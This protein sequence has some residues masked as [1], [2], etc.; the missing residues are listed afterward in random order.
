M[1]DFLRRSASS[2]V[3]KL[4]LG[5][6][7]ASFAVWGIGDIFRINTGSDAVVTVGKA[8]ITVPQFRAELA[9]ELDR[10]S[11]ILGQPVSR[12]QAV[13]MGVDQMLL[14]RMVN[15]QV[16]L[17]GAKDLDL[18]AS[19]AVVRGEIEKN[20]E[21]F[22]EAGQFDR[23]IYTEVLSRAGLSEAMYVARVRDSIMRMQ[24]LSPISTG[25]V[26]PKALVDVLYKRF[27]E[28]RVLD[29]VR[30]THAK[31][32]DVPAPSDEQ[33]TQY[34]ADNAQRFMAPEYRA[35]TALVLSA[36]VLG[37]GI[38]VTDEELATA[39]D[40]RAAEF[41]T[42]ETRTLSQI[43][44]K[45][46]AAAARA[47]E[48]L[49]AG[50]TITQAADEVGANASMIKL[51]EFSRDEAAALS[52]EIADAAFTTPQGG[53]SAPVKSPLGWHVLVVD[54]ITPGH[55]RTLDDVKAE[56]T[57]SIRNERTLNVLFE[58]SNQLEDQLGSGQTLEEAAT[59]LGLKLVHI[60]SVDVGGLG[61]DG[62]P[63][64]APYADAMVA[65]AFEL[66]EGADSALTETADNQAFFVVRVDAVT[67]PA[68]RPLDTV[69]QQ[70]SAAWMQEQRAAKAET[71]A[72]SVK[73]R[74]QAGEDAQTV[75]R[76]LG[77]DA[78]TTEPFNRAGQGLENGALPA[79]LMND[80]F[81]LNV[82]DVV[83]ALGTD[84]HTVAR[85]KSVNQAEVDQANPTYRAVH[86]QTLQTLQTDLAAQLSTA[87]QEDHPVRVNSAVLQDLAN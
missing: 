50:K 16:L 2:I 54:A 11:Q 35:L 32:T 10:V 45:D 18:M 24:Y 29:V 79:T 23:R 43:L 20:E 31:I 59:G 39:Y 58:T 34:H 68:L 37:Q 81:T 22:N 25:T 48:L 72:T 71:V 84:A 51:G 52:V 65:T 1:L 67:P 40:D 7:I 80:V 9:R 12:E 13:A 30:I 53:H 57:Q 5:L 83:A 15:S 85:L 62:A 76:A 86:D 28:T 60:A 19:D 47:A 75:A 21:F 38:D 49:S 66:S 14:Q 64:D 56:L 36:D 26:A 69:K 46:E 42:L 33:L 70:V 3:V 55:A 74:L 17:E 78:F 73:A 41:T 63:V 27:A 87:L 4:L 77:F 82:G 8:D 44:V 6:L 61:P